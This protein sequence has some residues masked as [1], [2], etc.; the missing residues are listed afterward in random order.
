[1]H[2]ESD[3]GCNVRLK[4]ASAQARVSATGAA[5]GVLLLAALLLLGGCASDVRRSQP[6][7]AG[8]RIAALQGDMRGVL[9]ALRESGARGAGIPV[10]LASCVRGRLDPDGAGAQASGAQASGAQA[11]G[12]QAADAQDSPGDGQG[13]LSPASLALLAAFESYWRGLLL[14][15]QGPDQAENDLLQAVGATVVG[16][17]PNVFQTPDPTVNAT[18]LRNALAGTLDDASAPGTGAGSLHAF[19]GESRGLIDL[20]LWRTAQVR[21]YVVP[22]PDGNVEVRVTL[23]KDADVRGWLAWATCGIESDQA[24]VSPGELHVLAEGPGSVDVE[25]DAFRA[26]LLG[27]Y[28]QQQWDGAQLPS[29][30]PAEVEYRASLAVLARSAANSYSQAWLQGR[31]AIAAAGRGEPRRHAA[32]W[33]MRQL[34]KQLF[35]AATI[36]PDDARW[37]G[38][39]ADALAKAARALLLDSSQQVRMANVRAEREG[40]PPVGFFLPD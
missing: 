40:G 38:L 27:Y 20:V 10:A 1:M 26:G 32:Y 33:L 8:L 18:Q 19:I 14:Q 5:G 30:E 29:L 25:S 24:W 28:G 9:A 17:Q 36:A 7:A 35:N 21:S 39:G 37:R 16:R 2:A 22:L 34:G 4:A 15:E 6:G 11:P 3:K 23:V 12:A 13:A 31:L